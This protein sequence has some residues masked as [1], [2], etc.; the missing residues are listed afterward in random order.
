MNIHL[1]FSSLL[2]FFR[3]CILPSLLPF[4]CSSNLPFIIQSL[5]FC[6]PFPG[7]PSLYFTFCCFCGFHNSIVVDRCKHTANGKA[8][9]RNMCHVDMRI[10]KRNATEK[11]CQQK[12]SQLLSKNPRSTKS[13]KQKKWCNHRKE[14]IQIIKTTADWLRKRKYSS[15]LEGVD[16]TTNHIGPESSLTYTETN[17]TTI[18][19]AFRLLNLIYFL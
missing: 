1:S 10:H 14:T 2:V 15:P 11:R 6:L 8:S 17:I 16:Q 3:S 18:F 4:L 13:F 5:L 19:L 12:K 9:C 7:L